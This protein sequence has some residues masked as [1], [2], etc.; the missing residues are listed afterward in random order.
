MINNMSEQGVRRVPK[1]RAGEYTIDEL[2][3][4]SHVTVR[5]IRAH[6]SRGLLPAPEVRGRTGFY[7]D[8]H[9]A[10]LQLI[11]EM[12]A[13]GFNLNAVKRI[14]DGM[15][16]GSAGEVLGFERALR[17]P[18]GSEDTEI[19]NIDELA[20][21]L[22][23]GDD[24]TARRAAKLGLMVPL[25]DGRFEIIS[26][27]L[28]RAGAQLGELGVDVNTRLAVE[29]QVKR[30]TDAIADAFT[31]LFLEKVWKPF[32]EAGRPESEWPRIRA[33]LDMLRPL[34]TEV[35]VAT[36]YLS[37][38]A[39]VD[40]AFG[41]AIQQE[42]KVKPEAKRRERPRREKPQVRREAARPGRSRSPK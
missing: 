31:R 41:K 40:E 9:L 14:L 37:M 6:Q 25:G 12:Q 27:T 20:E 22:P 13:D 11:S 35:T 3:Q 38:T 24:G 26:P 18:W 23:G 29:E 39:A 36:F 32:H 4:A 30:H 2:A 28:L 33:A 15:R 7:T 42:V 16:P 1:A 21:M 17:A 8:E 5:N 19:M 34:S 10:R